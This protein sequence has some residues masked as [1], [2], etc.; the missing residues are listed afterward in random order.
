MFTASRSV[1]LS[2]IDID[3]NTRNE[4]KEKG[5]WGWGLFETISALYC[6]APPRAFI[7]KT[8]D[9]DDKTKNKER[10]IPSKRTRTLKRPR[11][12]KTQKR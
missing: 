2:T 6:R 1:T 7:K 12:T 11:Y 10:F 3:R 4:K 8:D 5:L 9:D